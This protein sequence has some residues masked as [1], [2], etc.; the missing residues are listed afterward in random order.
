MLSYVHNNNLYKSIGFTLK[1]YNDILNAIPVT[2]KIQASLM[3]KINPEE[4]KLSIYENTYV[5]E[6]V[7]LENIYSKGSNVT[8]IDNSIIKDS[9]SYRLQF[10]PKDG[11][12]IEI[13][14]CKVLYKKDGKIDH[15]QSLL[16][17]GNNFVI[18]SL[19]YLVSTSTKKSIKGLNKINN[20]YGLVDIESQEGFTLANNT[21]QGSGSIIINGLGGNIL[22]YFIECDMSPLPKQYIEYNSA[23]CT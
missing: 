4:F 21:I 16:S 22:N 3:K 19:G 6:K 7:S 13:K 20:S 5:D 9:Y 12:N 2:Y 10:I 1:S 14:K 15:E 23:D 8:K 17:P 11:S 18:N